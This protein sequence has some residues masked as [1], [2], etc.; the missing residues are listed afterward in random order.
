MRTAPCCSY[1]A[2]FSHAGGHPIQ[3]KHLDFNPAKELCTCCQPN[4]SV[5][6][7]PA[8]VSSALL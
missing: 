2:Q 5:E 1:A 7:F 8:E 4:F 3:P 6:L